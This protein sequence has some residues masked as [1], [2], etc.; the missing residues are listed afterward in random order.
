[1]SEASAIFSYLIGGISIG[2]ILLCVS[3]LAHERLSKRA[4]RRRLERI[5]Q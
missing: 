4:H 5:L 1:M 2:P 3:L